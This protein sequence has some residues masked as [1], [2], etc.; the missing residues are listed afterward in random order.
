VSL[1]WRDRVDVFLAPDRVDLTWRRRGLRRHVAA[2]CSRDCPPGASAADWRPAIA[3]L[4]GALEALGGRRADAQVTL[5]NHFVRFALVPGAGSLARADER[6]AL[7]RHV[8]R[9]VFGD[10]AE[11][12]TI[13]LA[14]PVSGDGVAAGV[15][16]ELVAALRAACA[17]ASV[18]LGAVRPFLA[19]AFD[20]ARPSLAPGAAWFA[21]AEPGR[22]CVAHLDGRRWVA[23]RSQR[24]VDPL[25]EAL[26]LALDQTRL[27]HG[28]PADGEV[29]LVMRDAGLAAFDRAGE[30]PLRSLALAAA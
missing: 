13:A 23:L 15:D 1:S 28:L 30:W 16:S 26:A 29:C 9:T 25:P 10:H 12:W 6:R 14:E 11:S 4:G 5:S 3:A 7:A 27:A 8:L 19:A 18:T 20:R 21:A 17:S 22:V 24:A 2:A